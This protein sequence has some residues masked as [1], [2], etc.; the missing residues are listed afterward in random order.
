MYFFL[1]LTVHLPKFSISTRAKLS[2]PLKRWYPATEELFDSNG[3]AGKY[4]RPCT[5]YT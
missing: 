2:A 5:P 1:Q 3:G 4:A